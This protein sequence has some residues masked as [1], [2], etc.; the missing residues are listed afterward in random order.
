MPAHGL[1]QVEINGERVGDEE[2]TPGWTSYHHRLRYATFDATELVRPGANAI[3]VWLAD[4]W[5]RGRL[6][7]G[8]SVPDIYGDRLAALVQL[9]V[10]TEGGRLVTVASDGTWSAGPGPVLAAGL[11]DGERF[12]LR[13]HDG[14]WSTPC[15][16]DEGWGPVEILPRRGELVAPSGP[17]VRCTEELTPTTIDDKGDGRWLVDFGQN[18]SGRRPR[19]PLSR[20]RTATSWRPRTSHTPR[21]AS[22]RS[23][24][25]SARTGRR[26]TGPRSPTT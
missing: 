4:G 12:D 6:G 3:G 19:T 24:P 1:A 22:R 14:S 25:C 11:Y 7:F 20:R 23:P 26:T 13:L 2:L 17:A 10:V 5:S 15:F 9:E 18:H 16:A 21:D 8:E